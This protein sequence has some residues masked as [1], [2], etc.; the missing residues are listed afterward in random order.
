MLAVKLCSVT[1]SLCAVSFP[2]F[3]VFSFFA[4]KFKFA[5]RMLLDSS[6][7]SDKMHCLTPVIAVLANSAPLPGY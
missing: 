1:V 4:S 6:R 5:P 2:H 7:I 3:A